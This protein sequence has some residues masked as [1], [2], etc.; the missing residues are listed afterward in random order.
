MR[1]LFVGMLAA[2]AGCQ[3]YHANTDPQIAAQVGALAV[4]RTVPD[5]LPVEGNSSLPI[6]PEPLDLPELWNLALANNPALREA[7]AN[8]E[9]ARGRLIQA[10]LYPNPAFAYSQENIGTPDDPVGSTILEVTQE[11]VTAGKRQLDIRIN[12]RGVDAATVA[13]LGQ[14][15]TVL[16]SIRS[17]YYDY[18]GWAYAV[19]IDEEAATRLEEGLRITR[20]L[21]EEA[22]TRPRTDLLQIEGLLAQA[23]LDL[24]N[25]R[26]NQQAAWGQL[27]ARVGLPNLRMP[28]TAGTLA[29][30]APLWDAEAV[31]QRI[32]SANT[33]LKQAAVEA[34]QARLQVERARAAAVPNVT[35]GGGWGKNFADPA[36][37]TGAIVTV[38]APLPLWDRKQGQIHEAEASWA[39]AQAAVRTTA[40]QLSD[41]TAAALGRYVSARQQVEQLTREILP[42]LQQSVELLRKGYQIGAA[43]ITFADVLLAEQAFFTSRKALAG[44][45]RSL[46]L[47]IAD[48]QG[49]MQLDLDEELSAAAQPCP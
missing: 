49:L 26:T 48:L 10:G 38:Q 39:R 15:F 2:L 34:E 44:T 3:A 21:V 9:A 27:A 17:A 42:R 37:E 14:K 19:Q 31:R 22:K 46:W 35:L 23:R 13:L 7:A 11:I 33:R 30:Q 41:E 20:R 45:R 36:A 28:A 6:L 25:S 32:L 8:I 1:S 5:V 12:T 24:A 18:L 4:A 43:G 47:A 29:E 40:M 16:T